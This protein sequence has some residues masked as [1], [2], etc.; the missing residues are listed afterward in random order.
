MIIQVFLLGFVFSFLGSMS[1]GTLNILVLQLGLEKKVRAALR[2]ALA[3]ALVEFP[4]AWI[5]VEFEDWITSSPSISRNFQLTG[6]LVMTA[7]GGFHVWSAR[8]PS[9][10]SVRFQES[11]FWRGLILSLLNPQSIPFWI[12]VT[13]YLKA[14]GW[15]DLRSPWLLCGYLFGASLG[16]MSLLSLLAVLSQK[17]SGIFQQSRLLR[18]MPG[19][20]LLLLGGIGLARYFIS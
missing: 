16:V 5:G 8:K 3:V 11:G 18:M 14:E 15:I 13:A 20:V 6:A 7:I 2:F 19:L 9:R 10:F 17:L 12:V 1:P 4:Y